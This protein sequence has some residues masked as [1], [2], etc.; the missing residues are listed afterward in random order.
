[1]CTAVVTATFKIPG[2]DGPPVLIR[3][4]ANIDRLASDFLHQLPTRSSSNPGFYGAMLWP[5]SLLL[6]QMVAEAPD[7]GGGMTSLEVSASDPT[8]AA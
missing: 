7:L 2:L 8:P 1:M 4:A 3:Q 5:G 6:A